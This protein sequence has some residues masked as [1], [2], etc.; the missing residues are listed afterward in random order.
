MTCYRCTGTVVKGDDGP[1]CLLCARPQPQG[2]VLPIYINKVA[3]PPRVAMAETSRCKCGMGIS[4][5]NKSGKCWEC[6]QRA[7]RTSLNEMRAA[8]QKALGI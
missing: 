3:G 2:Q 8:M 7:T 5:R 6:S 1:V 4:D